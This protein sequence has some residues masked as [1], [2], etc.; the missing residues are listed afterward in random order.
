MKFQIKDL[1]FYYNKV[2][3]LHRI[4]LDI[5]EQCATALIGP[6]GCGKTTLLRTLNAIHK[7]YPNH[8]MEGTILLDNQNIEEEDVTLLRKKVGMVFQHP[9]PFPMSIID[10]I[11][12]GIKLHERLKKKDL[13][14]RVEW[15]LTEASLWDEVKDK[16]HQSGLGL[17]IGQQQRLCIARTIAIKPEVILFDEPTSALDPISTEKIE[18]LFHRLKK[19]YTL[20]IVTHNMQQAYR[21]SD[22]I[23]FLYKGELIEFNTTEMIFKN[24]KEEKTGEY[25]QGKCS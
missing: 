3:A 2:K 14:E 23:A 8:H 22:F 4:N 5:P 12:F 15:A 19:H 24:A 17:S 6:S 9:T 1:S 18:Q 13:A 20:I 7:L 10:N 21:I 25:I 16:L 11:T